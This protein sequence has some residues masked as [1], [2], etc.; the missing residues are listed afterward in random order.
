MVAADTAP[1][2][3]GG[4]GGR[5][6]AILAVAPCGRGLAAQQ[7]AGA[8]AQRKQHRGGATAYRIYTKF[9]SG[10]LAA[11]KINTSSDEANHDGSTKFS[12]R[13]SSLP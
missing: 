12:I 4:G 13:D 3:R 6:I 11:T 2:H 7:G 5:P 9:S 10:N 8:R 1:R